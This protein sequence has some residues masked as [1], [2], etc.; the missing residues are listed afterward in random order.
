VATPRLIN[1]AD[2]Q[3]LICAFQLAPVVTGVAELSRAKSPN[4]VWLH[5]NLADS[6]AS[7]WI[8]ENPEIPPAARE[9][10]VDSDPRIHSQILPDGLLAV[11]G[12]L[13]HDFNADPEGFGTLRVYVS[14]RQ[15]ISARRHP[16]KT[17]DVLRRELRTGT[18]ISSPIALFE[19]LIDRLADT[20]GD[21]VGE[22]GDQVDDAEDKILGGQLHDHGSKLGSMRRLL[23]R[24]RRHI[25]A[26][27]TAL[28]P[29]PAR[30][31]QFCGDEQ[32]QGL[33]HAIERLEAVA[34]DLELVQERARLLQEEI[35]G[36]LGEA[37]NRNLFV[38]SVITAALLPI[39][40]ITGIF[41]MNVGGLPLAEH[42]HG[43]AW[44]LVMMVLI[45]VGSL[46]LLRR[47]R[48]V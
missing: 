9:L 19:I 40:L 27:R 4:P 47:G 18:T 7:R 11:L 1:E 24:L 32:R 21:V 46:L 8:E 37:T 48:I 13:H 14:E 15:M 28:V 3:G 31:P 2:N 34:Q 41:G 16:L 20:F 12:D 25:T 45:L 44:I 10:L 36:R 5:F 22:L 35:A 30:L 29:L 33:R 38:L 43:F 17:V 42:P 26:N 39:T 6:R 23:A